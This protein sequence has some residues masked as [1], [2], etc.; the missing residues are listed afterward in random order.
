MG[1]TKNP[2]TDLTSFSKTGSRSSIS[3]YP[4]LAFFVGH[5]VEEMSVGDVVELARFRPLDVTSDA[6]VATLL[7]TT[8]D[9]VVG[10]VQAMARRDPTAARAFA[11]QVQVAWVRSMDGARGPKE[12]VEIVTA[13]EYARRRAMEI[14]RLAGESVVASMVAK[15]DQSKHENTKKP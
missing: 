9:F 11:D 6:Y 3:D 7:R 12:I 14:G 4:R 10:Y 2:E 1:I 8:S 13:T 15:N 5:Q